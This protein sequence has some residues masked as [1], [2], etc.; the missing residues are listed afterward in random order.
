MY[1]GDDQITME[2]KV[3]QSGFKHTAGS[4]APPGSENKS[5]SSI[6]RVK[7]EEMVLLGGLEEKRKASI[8]SGLPFLARIPVI[9][10]FFSNRSKEKSDSQL[11]I[12]IRPTIL[13]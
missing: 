1:S 10:W 12:F 6:M 4:D 7:N 13:F 2:I 3:S 5:F 9:K 11:N 8:G